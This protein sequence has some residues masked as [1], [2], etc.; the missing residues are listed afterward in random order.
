MLLNT[1]VRESSSSK[2]FGK[3]CFRHDM[4]DQRKVDVVQQLVA[5]NKRKDSIS[6]D[7]MNCAITLQR[8]PS[9]NDKMMANNL[10][11]NIR[12]TFQKLYEISLV[13]VEGFDKNLL[14]FVENHVSMF[15]KYE[16][17]VVYVYLKQANADVYCAK[18]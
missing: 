10:I 2:N 4:D 8:L 1:E 5:K 12:T 9:A 11:K 6:V 18:K 16:N 3:N 13:I 14:I 17:K 15:I 7:G